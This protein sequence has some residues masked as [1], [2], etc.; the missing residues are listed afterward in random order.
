MSISLG[1]LEVVLIGG[2]AS[3]F[4]AEVKRLQAEHALMRSALTGIRHASTT[5]DMF[6]LI[7]RIDSLRAIAI[8]ALDSLK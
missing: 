5:G 2:E 6:T 3:P 1:G 7:Q 8:G 4:Y